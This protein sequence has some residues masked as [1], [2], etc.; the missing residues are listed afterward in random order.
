M[1]LIFLRLLNKIGILKFLIFNVRTEIYSNTFSI[2]IIKGIGIKNIKSTESWMV[3][4]LHKLIPLVEDKTFIDVGVNIGQTLLKLKSVSQK[5]NYIGFEPNPSAV[6]YTN[7]LI[8]SNHFK[9]TA[10]VPIGLSNKTEVLTLKLY[11]KSDVDASASILA[12]FRPN[13]KI[14]EEKYIPVFHVND[15]T[16]LKSS[17]EKV[18]I[19]K[20]DVE[21]AE[22]EVLESLE[23]VIGIAYPLILMEILPVYNTD[24]TYRIERQEKI[25]RILHQFNY[26]IYRIIK[27]N[28]NNTPII[29]EKIESI[30]IH[31]DLSKCDYIFVP[32]DKSDVF[33]NII[34]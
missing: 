7:E 17:L 29:F 1:I 21:G 11:N 31:N 34:R 28:Q 3:S 27:S 23:K 14:I 4:L 18:G 30:G 33:S 12:E 13:E 20:I 25:E 26:S 2:P 10:I 22:L 5:M 9:N 32:K 6:F 16:N 8:K 19:L 15:L 24:N